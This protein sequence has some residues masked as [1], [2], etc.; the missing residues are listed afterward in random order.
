VGRIGGD[1]TV[2]GVVE[3]DP[4]QVFG[5]RSREVMAEGKLDRADS[6]ERGGGIGDGNVP[7]RVL[8]AEREL[9]GL[10]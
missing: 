10:C 8:V 3:P 4:A 7:V 5:R 9:W 6:D 2:V 1:Q